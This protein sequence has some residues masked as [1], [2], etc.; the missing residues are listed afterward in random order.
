MGNKTSFKKGQK[1][2]NKGIT[3]KD[4]HSYGQNRKGLSGKDNPFFGKTRSKETIKKMREAKIGKTGNTLGKTWKV[5][6]TS[7]MIHKKG[8][9]HWNWQGGIS[10]KN[11]LERARFKQIVQKKVL[12]RDNYTCQM[13]DERGGYL[14]VDHIQSWSEYVEL[15]FDMKNLRTLCMDCHYLVTFGKKKPEDLIWGHNFK[16]KK[17]E[18]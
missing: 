11:D 3:G 16:H 9:D 10:S 6:D 15:R 4:S 18:V 1:P 17:V 14:Q 12:E 7:R 13:C 8:K 5:K 2:W